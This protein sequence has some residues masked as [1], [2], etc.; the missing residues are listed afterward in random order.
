MTAPHRPLEKHYVSDEDRQRYVIEL[1]ERS[2]HHYDR[3]NQV[4]S[5]GF[6]LSYRAQALGRAGLAPGMRV[7]DVAT[8]TGLMARAAVRVVRD[9]RR[10]I[11]LDPTAGMLHA[12][13]R[14]AVMPLVRGL[15]ETLPFASGAFD[16]LTM[17]YAL[18]HVPDLE[19]AFREYH[20]VLRPGGRVLLLEITAPASRVGRAL[21]RLYLARVVP[22]LTRMVTRS[23]DAEALTRY[24]WDTIVE[25]VPPTVILS[26]LR[27]AGFHDAHRRTFGGLLSE[28]VASR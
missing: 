26:A 2:A 10:V 17:G 1:F 20:R 15:G 9:A 11:G 18:R 8:G 13:R 7:L 25:C 14:T 27:D 22:A 28:Y 4:M 5:L 23:A 21:C 12:A 3:I 16:F 19:T 24:Y 6:A